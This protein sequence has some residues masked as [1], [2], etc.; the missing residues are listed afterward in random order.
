MADRR[1]REAEGQDQSQEAGK[2]ERKA[3]DRLV[4]LGASKQPGRRHGQKFNRIGFQS[5]LGLRR[6][7]ATHVIW[8]GLNKCASAQL[9]RRLDGIIEAFGRHPGIQNG[10]R[11]G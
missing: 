6:D 8:P 4:R 10:K 5:V 9:P 11:R 2:K 7:T 3:D 1:D